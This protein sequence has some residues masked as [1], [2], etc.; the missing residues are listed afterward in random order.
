MADEIL[1]KV[2]ADI[3]GFSADMQEAKKIGNSAIQE[4]EKN[5]IDLKIGNAAELTATLKGIAKEGG[6]AFAGLEN[7]VEAVVNDTAKLK[8][9][10]GE[11]TNSLK[12]V[13]QGSQEF[14]VLSEIIRASNV[15]L[16]NLNSTTVKT[17][18]SLRTQMRKAQQEVAELSAKFGTTSTQAIEAAK[19]AAELKD[20][21]GDAKALTDAFNPDAKFA[22]LSGS[23][24]GVASGFQA[25][26]GFIGAFG[27]ESK[28]V[29]QAL[30]KVNSAMALSQGLQGLFSSIDSF[31]ILGGV[32]K[33]QV[34]GAFTTLRGAIAATGLG[35]LAVTI[36]TI[37]A[38]WEELVGWIEKTFPAFQNVTNFFKNFQQNAAG[39]LS[40]VVAG[41]KTVGEVVSKIFRGDF[42]GALASASN[43]GSNMS[44][45]FNQG[46]N[47][48][49]IELK[50]AALEN[51]KKNNNAKIKM[52]GA[53][54]KKAA[55]EYNKNY[56]DTVKTTV[57]GQQST[58]EEYE[59]IREIAE[60]SLLSPYEAQKKKILENYG[61]QILLAE[62]YG[63]ETLGIEQKM[64]EELDALDKKQ[65]EN[66]QKNID[67][68]NI[69]LGDAAKRGF[70]TRE[71][72]E[73]R[74]FEE[75]K[76]NL[77]DILSFAQNGILLKIGINP[78]DVERVKSGILNTMDV[79]KANQKVLD[80]V[81]ATAKEQAQARLENLQAISQTIASGISTIS[82]SI[83][84]ADA[85]RRQEELAALQ[86]QKEEELR[87]A[88]DNE[89]KKDIIRQKYALKEKE[90]KRKQAEA[91]KRKAIF[92]AIIGTAVA[93]IK[94][95][96][97]FVLAA[98]TGAL[99]AA[100]IALIAAQP[101]P[102]FAKGGAVPSSD[103]NGMIS[104]R[105]HA[106][107]G[108]L[109]EAEG[110]EFITRKAQAMKSDNLGLLEAINLSDKERDAYINRHY[111]MPAIQAKESKAKE[112]YRHSQIEAE[113]NLIAR[114]SS[115]T[116]K[117][118]HREQKN[119]T[120]AIKRLDKKDFKW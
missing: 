106:A 17:G 87:L 15:Q 1:I 83:F 104:G 85:Q 101:I 64:F 58:A 21:I 6:A 2:R 76:K 105:P 42:S 52:S 48:K 25:A 97:N 90:I 71:E 23:I 68:V 63:L 65:A 98:I 32:I 30:L 84:E 86:S 79:I 56:A 47:N 41:F 115:H 29:E 117:S 70:E 38:N 103:I 51:E 100:Q 53:A 119:T 96:P 33:T 49:D 118:I 14:N 80:D 108:V 37:V 54:G 46:Y 18:E 55:E 73:K 60:E 62:Q 59:K 40:S 112:V 116:L 67:S 5:T 43:L 27:A 91:D 9:F 36:G 109:I 69:A 4:L 28:E 3:D 95:L 82:N 45:A 61:Q 11:L 89:Q 12:N 75:Q 94:S 39:V 93:V 35:L 16:N 34:I 114:V 10:I 120:E 81:N 57:G 107:G 7:G 72:Y 111:V 24:Q 92:D 78:Q 22:A 31:K 74:L 102:K 99:G 77:N 8:Q 66:K 26:Q 113:N 44:K 19:R 13:K 110:N 50:K 20:V 88:G